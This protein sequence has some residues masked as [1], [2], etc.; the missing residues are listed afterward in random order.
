[1][2]LAA[3]DCELPGEL[4]AQEPLADRAGARMLVLHRAGRRWEDRRFRDFPEFLGPGDCLVLNDSRVFPARLFGRRVGV[5]A[6]PI[7]KKNP[8][9][10]EYLSREVEVFLLRAVSL[11]GRDWEAL[12]RPGRKMPVGERVGFADGLVGEI[13][14]RGEFGERTVRLRPL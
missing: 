7:G 9:R 1:M 6:L 11:D 4:I 14:A 12:V 3:F 10:R 2:D 5:R 8:K 13:I